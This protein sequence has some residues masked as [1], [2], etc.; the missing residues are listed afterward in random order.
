LA[1][2]LTKRWLRLHGTAVSAMVAP[3]EAIR[4]QL[5]V[6]TDPASMDGVRAALRR[7]TPAQTLTIALEI[8]DIRVVQIAAEEVAR[9]PK[10]LNDADVGDASI[11]E[12]WVRALSINSDAWRG[13]AEPQRAFTLVVDNLMDGKAVNADLIL[14]LSSSPIADLCDYPRRAEVWNRVGS[15]ACSKLVRAT[16]DGWLRRAVSG[17][18]PYPPDRELEA[19][20][21]SG[22]ALD[23][24]LR[25]LLQTDAGASARILL[26][27]SGY[28]ES[29]L[30]GWLGELAVSRRAL[31]AADAESL[32]R[33][34]L[35]RRWQRAVGEWCTCV[36]RA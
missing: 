2:A 20:L 21:L 28:D 1:L 17:T 23:R 24:A 3:H 18:V 8:A 14:A 27:L 16:A 29:R 4:R 30:L 34:V 19:V 15:T 9:Q 5:S 22:D 6:E 35:A 7:A 33:L 25:E 10:L 11:Q 31:P 26:A 32:G 13:L 36:E 12:V